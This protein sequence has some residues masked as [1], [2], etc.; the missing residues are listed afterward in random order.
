MTDA[1][2]G[3]RTIPRA[4]QD[5]CRNPPHNEGIRKDVRLLEARTHHARTLTGNRDHLFH[6]KT[7]RA[8]VR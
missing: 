7:R 2:E 8:K 4:R 6:L 5:E 1:Y 3:A